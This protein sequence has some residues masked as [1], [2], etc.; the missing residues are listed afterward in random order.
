MTGKNFKE[1]KAFAISGWP[2]IIIMIIFI[3][4]SAFILLS[5]YSNSGTIIKTA[6]LLGPLNFIIFFFTIT[7]LFVINPNQAKLFLFLGHYAGT[8]RKH[9]LQW[10]IP[11]FSKR[12]ISLKIRNFE[13]QKLKINDNEG[14]P[15]E[16]GAIIVW[17]VFDT[18]QA[19]F[20]VQD[21]NHFVRVQSE[22]AIRSLIMQ[23]SYDD[24][25]DEARSLI[26]NTQEVSGKLKQETQERLTIAGIEIVETKISHL[27]YSPE[28]A[29]AMLRRQQA[30]AVVAARTEIVHGAVGMVEIAL[31]MIEEKKLVILNEE[32][33]SKMVSNLLVV[34]CSEQNTQPTLET[35]L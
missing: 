27:A 12:T 23:Y 21:F 7:G 29:A 31:E 10:T 11:I 9:G 6:S 25:Q 1:K 15:V 14:N 17:R 20:E 33:K 19:S 24:Y 8:V 2:I 34:L 16:V 32:I 5:V 4:I 3:I 35:T 22:S 30:K 13:S 26:K 28:I 18:A